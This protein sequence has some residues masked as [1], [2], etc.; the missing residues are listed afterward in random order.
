MDRVASGST[1]Q[2]PS[3]GRRIWL[4]VRT[5]AGAVGLLGVY[6][7]SFR[8]YGDPKPQY[9]PIPTS[10]DVR[11]GEAAFV[12]VRSVP[13][14]TVPL[15]SI[16]AH[17]ERNTAEATITVV[18]C[19]PPGPSYG[20]VVEPRSWCARTEKV[21]SGRTSIGFGAWQVVLKVT[22]QHA[23]VV[24]LTGVSIALTEAGRI[25]IESVA[26]PFTVTVHP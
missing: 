21:H 13:D 3:R 15:Q 5:L 26:Y 11:Q 24:Q 19:L 18:L 7:F 25:A 8:F 4:R 22:P 6:A 2:P 23:G 17:V 12:N 16:R 14:A 9:V 1:E 10:V 20:Q